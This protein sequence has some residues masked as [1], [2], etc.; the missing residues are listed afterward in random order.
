[1]R[2]LISAEFLLTF[3][4][5]TAILKSQEKRRQAV[6]DRLGSRDYSLVHVGVT[7]NRYGKIEKLGVKLPQLALT[8]TTPNGVNSAKLRF[9]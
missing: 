7:P 2:R 6:T 8:R 3:F 9:A 4:R 1:M 5:N